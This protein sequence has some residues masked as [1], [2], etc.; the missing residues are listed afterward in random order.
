MAGAVPLPEKFEGANT[1]HLR[2]I[3]GKVYHLSELDAFYVDSYGVLHAT[4]GDGRRVISGDWNDALVKDEEGYWRFEDNG[5][6]LTAVKDKAKVTIDRDAEQIR[7]RVVTPGDGQMA[8]YMAQEAEAKILKA[9]INSPIPTPY[10]DALVGIIAPTKQE[11]VDVVL[12][13]A[14]QWNSINAQINAVRLRT[15]ADVDAA[16]TEEQIASIVATAGW[17]IVSA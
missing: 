2:V 4:P 10:L 14:E 8:T 1:Q 3:S 13:M 9:D 5:E 7:A 11:V 17:P 6:K 16:T 15:K 12:V